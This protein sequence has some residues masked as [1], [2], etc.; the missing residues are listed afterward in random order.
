LTAAGRVAVE[1]LGDGKSS[2]A[3]LT[4][5]FPI[6]KPIPKNSAHRTTSPK[7]KASILPVPSVISVSSDA[8]HCEVVNG[9][10]KASSYLAVFPA[11]SF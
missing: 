9:V 3:V 8:S 4:E 7:N 6:E 5:F 2:G 10:I 11:I 1:G